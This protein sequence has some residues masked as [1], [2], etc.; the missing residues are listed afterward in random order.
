MLKSSKITITALLES[1]QQVLRYG[2]YQVVVMPLL[3][4]VSSS[5]ISLFS[6]DQANLLR[7]TSKRT[8]R[9]TLTRLL[10]AMRKWTRTS[11]RPKTYRSSNLRCLNLKARWFQRTI[12]RTTHTNIAINKYLLHRNQNPLK[13]TT[14][15]SNQSKIR[16][17]RMT[18]L[19]T[20]S[21]RSRP[22]SW[23]ICLSY[24]KLMIKPR[25]PWSSTRSRC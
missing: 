14:V 24:S 8:Y 13:S 17:L 6:L 2:W 21:P 7:F 16:T 22:T 15:F 12:Q 11:S 19:N 1:T 18:F 23:I 10:P 9:A 3:N 25:A 4:Q 20:L 5:D